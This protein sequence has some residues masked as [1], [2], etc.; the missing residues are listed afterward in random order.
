MV[1]RENQYVSIDIAALEKPTNSQNKGRRI[2]YNFLTWAD[3]GNHGHVV[4]GNIAQAVLSDD[5]LEHNLGEMRVALNADSIVVDV[6][7]P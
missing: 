3:A 1:P 6:I 2:F 4:D 5:A 7:V